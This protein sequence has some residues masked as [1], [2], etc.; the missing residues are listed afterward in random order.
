LTT[1]QRPE[2]KPLG[3][4]LL[5]TQQWI[6]EGVRQLM[7]RRG[8]S[9]ITVPHLLFIAHLDCGVTHAS[10]VAKRMGVTRQ[11]VYKTTRELQ[12]LSLLTLDVDPERRNQKIIHMT[13]R[14]RRAV[15]DALDCL[16]RVEKEV[17]SRL[18]TENFSR[19]KNML[20]RD[21]GPPLGAR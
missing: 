6:F 11:A 16:S 5:G 18:G 21:W 1:I 13:A 20:R 4:L 3:Q 14:G 2:G 8:H 7:T 17:E 19:L 12:K 9:K 15:T 10:L